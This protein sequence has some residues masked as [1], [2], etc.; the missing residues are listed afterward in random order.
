ME[1]LLLVLL[2]GL[3]LFTMQRNSKRRRAIANVQSSLGPG[4]EVMLSSGLFAK[5][6]SVDDDRVTLE[7]SPGQQSTWDRRAV[8]KIITAGVAETPA[9]SVPATQPPGDLELEAPGTGSSSGSG[10]S[11][12]IGSAAG[13]EPASSTEAASSTDKPWGSTPAPQPG[14]GDGDTAPKN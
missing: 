7:T 12:G 1:Y 9:E 14:L 13:I 6:I 4:S 10:S 5:V 11:S 2:F 8:L 3:L